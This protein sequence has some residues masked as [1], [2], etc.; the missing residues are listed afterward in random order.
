MFPLDFYG[1]KTA[2]EIA[3]A[4][5]SLQDYQEKS[6]KGRG[7]AYGQGVADGSSY[8]LY[9]SQVGEDTG[10]GDLFEHID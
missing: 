6:L 3:R 7:I 10:I 9:F 8:G 4:A 2:D 1:G 5:Y